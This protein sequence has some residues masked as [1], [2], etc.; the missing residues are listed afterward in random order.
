[1]NSFFVALED[2]ETV[3]VSGSD[4]AR[5]LQGQLTCDVAAL[6]DNTFTYGTACNNKGRIFA[7]FILARHDAD[8]HVM[9]SPGLGKIFIANLQKFIPFY[10]CSMQIMTEI[11]SIG[12]VGTDAVNTL[13][14]LQMEIPA[15][16]T[17]DNVAD[18][19]LYNLNPD[20][21]QFIF[22]ASE[23]H[24][25]ALKARIASNMPEANQGQW[26]I[27]NILSGHFPFTAEDVDKYTPQELHFDQTGYISFAKGC[28]TGQE[29]IARMHYRGKVKKRLYLLQLENFKNLP[30]GDPIEI[31][32]DSNTSL[33]FALKQI[34]D[35]KQTLFVIASLPLDLST[36]L[37]T[38]D[39]HTFSY[40]PLTTI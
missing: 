39:G 1:M 10:K 32:N 31:Y 3:L 19:W 28:Y 5:F 30:D 29:I 24:Y 23:D 38:K 9:L 26:E 36:S 15:P 17:G 12:L 35:N 22:S 6:A 40:R 34:I 11:K 20:N 27:Q 7:A 4:A 18:S 33:G 2:F 8:F 21:T 37:H 25:P 13:K 14:N 16:G